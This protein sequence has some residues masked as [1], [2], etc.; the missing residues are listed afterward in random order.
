MKCTCVRH[1]LNEQW[2]IFSW[3][4]ALESSHIHGWS[5]KMYTFVGQNISTFSK[6]LH[7]NLIVLSPWGFNVPDTAFTCS[8][9]LILTYFS[10]NLA[11][12]MSAMSAKRRCRGINHVCYKARFMLEFVN[13]VCFSLWMLLIKRL[14]YIEYNKMHSEITS[15][16]SPHAKVQRI[17][18]SFVHNVYMDV[19]D[20]Q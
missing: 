3:E 10:C 19:N 20:I 5:M 18:Q 2:C 4:C 7:T 16:F 12:Y 9:P 8:D 15:L 11:M 6:R 17:G 13:A 14:K 1:Y